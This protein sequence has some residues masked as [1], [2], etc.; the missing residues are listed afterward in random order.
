[1]N[2]VIDANIAVAMFVEL[3]Y[4]AKA[5]VMLADARSILAPDLIIPEAT[6]ALRRMVRLK[7]LGRD[8]A[9]QAIV[10]IPRLF[11]EIV[12]SRKLAKVALDFALKLN[13]PSYDCF[14]IALADER[15]ATL[16]T[17]DQKLL[18]CLSGLE[19]PIRHKSPGIV[20]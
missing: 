14:Y 2:Y 7:E 10:D 17:A 9:H 12:G 1:M 4:S 11:A 13:H 3:G 16:V 15:R 6:N 5:R 8:I 19:K 20:G 18:R